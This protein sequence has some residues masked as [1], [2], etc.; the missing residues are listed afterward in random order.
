MSG[1]FWAI[2]TLVIAMVIGTGFGVA[3]SVGLNLV[4][5]PDNTRLLITSS[6]MVVFG[7]LLLCWW[8]GHEPP[9][10]NNPPARPGQNGGKGGR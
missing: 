9:N 7:V 4:W 6:V 10:L 1:A 2:G 8:L 3:V 5:Q